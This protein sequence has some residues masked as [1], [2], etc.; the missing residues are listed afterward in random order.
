MYQ[1]L[2][3]PLPQ[4]G[5][6]GL[7]RRFV[8]LSKP[9]CSLKKSKV[10]IYQF[11]P[12]D[13]SVTMIKAITNSEALSLLPSDIPGLAPSYPIVVTGDE[14]LSQNKTQRKGKQSS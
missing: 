1:H 14:I 4:N 12:P 2:S 5:A 11:V 10:P 9:N 8:Y 13:L 3:H 6:L 7:I